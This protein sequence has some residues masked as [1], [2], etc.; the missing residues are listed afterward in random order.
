MADKNWT[1]TGIGNSWVILHPGLQRADEKEVEMIYDLQPIKK[2]DESFY[3]IMN[4]I[5]L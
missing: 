3:H 5:T 4:F 1:Q 2:D